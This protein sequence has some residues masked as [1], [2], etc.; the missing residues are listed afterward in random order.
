VTIRSDHELTALQRVGHLVA[1]TL[2]HMRGLV[3]P[4]ITTAALD[5]AA[6]RYARDE[7]GESAPQLTYDFPGFTCKFGVSA[8]YDCN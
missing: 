2:A 3:R 7:G 1:R 6:A 5:D 4:G 8:A